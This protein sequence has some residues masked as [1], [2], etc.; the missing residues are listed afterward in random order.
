LNILLSAALLAQGDRAAYFEAFIHGL[1]VKDGPSNFAHFV[2][3]RFLPPS[4]PSLRP[5]F[6]FLP[7]SS[8]S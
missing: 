8:P 3:V 5:S 4:L 2:K 1:M 6:P 7:D